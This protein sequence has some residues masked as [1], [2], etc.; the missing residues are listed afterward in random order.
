MEEMVVFAEEVAGCGG[1]IAAEAAAADRL[2]VVLF[3]RR[4]SVKLRSSGC[5]RL[6]LSEGEADS[7]LRG[8][9]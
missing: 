9:F 4:A 7:G 3:K 6:R 8:G 1:G 5:G 2:L